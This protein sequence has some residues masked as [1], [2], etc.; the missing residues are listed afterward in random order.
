M[1]ASYKSATGNPT[2]PTVRGTITS[3]DDQEYLTPALVSARI[4]EVALPIIMMFPLRMRSQS[5]TMRAR[6]SRLT[7]SPSP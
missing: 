3:T 1:Y 6:E 5:S 2:R 4:Q 7:S